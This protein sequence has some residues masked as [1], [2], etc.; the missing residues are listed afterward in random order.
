MGFV[1]GRGFKRIFM[2]G[3]ATDYCVGFSAL[4]AIQLELEVVV[5]EDACRAI[6]MGGSLEAIQEQFEAQGVKL[7]PSADI[8]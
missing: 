4:D 5:I 1:H 2:A 8:L 7:M 6:N 3:L